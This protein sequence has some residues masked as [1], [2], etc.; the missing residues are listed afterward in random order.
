MAVAMSHVKRRFG[1]SCEHFHTSA[2]VEFSHLAIYSMR[3]C[4]EAE[5]E[6]A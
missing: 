5:Q 6:V 3:F 1:S 2:P 4:E